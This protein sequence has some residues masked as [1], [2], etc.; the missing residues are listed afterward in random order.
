MI[1]LDNAAT[2]G[3][4]PAEVIKAV[5]KELSAPSNP[6]RSS[7]KRA[8]ES[9]NRIYEARELLA[10]LFKSDKPENFILTPNATYA[11][12]FAIK[13]LLKE[14][15][16]VI[17]TAMEHNSV[18]RPLAAL[19]EVSVTVLKGDDYGI[20][21]PEDVSEAIKPETALIIINH[22]SNVNGIIQRAEEISKA[23][24]EKNVPVLLDA[25]QTAGSVGIDSKFFAMI[26]FP[27][28][29]GLYGPQGTG[30]LYISPGVT[31]KTVIEGGTGS[32]SVNTGNP[33]F[34]PDRFESGTLNCPGVA[35][36]AEGL[37][38]VLKEG[39]ES[40]LSKEHSLLKTAYEGL[41]SIKNIKISSPPDI[42]SLSGLISFNIN[43][44][45]SQN[46]SEILSREYNIATRPG[47]HCAYPAHLRLGTEKSGSVR[48][49]LSC[50]NTGDE[51][52]KFLWAIRK[53]A[54]PFCAAFA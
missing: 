30:G 20:I 45:E 52:K 15:D 40:I 19:T 10:K 29:K 50:F 9:M 28:H 25:S 32:D 44:T 47:Y 42:S 14:G 33:V 12:N 54:H 17:T 18:I 5:V 2:T 13:G 46:V 4:K 43:G 6:G 1:Y 3:K 21:K 53:I 26:A 37:R 34:L 27:G 24:A 31:L 41:S 48:V 16:H 39:V 8:L 49:S 22:S 38:F 35:G 11:L 36:L 23:A 7:H 51:I